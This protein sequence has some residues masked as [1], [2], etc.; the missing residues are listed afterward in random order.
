METFTQRSLFRRPKRRY[1]TNCALL[2]AQMQLGFGLEMGNEVLAW[3][4]K[5]FVVQKL[6]LFNHLLQSRKADF[7][8]V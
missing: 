3:V 7:E 1:A 2:K 6:L 8:S 5:C 4:T